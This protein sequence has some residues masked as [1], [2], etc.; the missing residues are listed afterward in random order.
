MIAERLN[1]WNSV[2]KVGYLLDQVRHAWYLQHY[3]AYPN[4][5]CWWLKL[6]FRMLFIKLY[7][8]HMQ[9]LCIILVMTLVSLAA[10]NL[11]RV[12]LLLGP[13]IREDR[14]DLCGQRSG[15]LAC[16][17]DDYLEFV[18]WYLESRVFPLVNPV[19]PLVDENFSDQWHKNFSD[20][21]GR[22]EVGRKVLG[23][24]ISCFVF[25]SVDF[26]FLI[27]FFSNGWDLIGSK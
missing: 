19:V 21:W 25:Y 15:M 26:S 18:Y 6:Y 3:F 10:G 4:S 20:H 2:W 9:P 14:R 1:H 22:W 27:L 7:E 24:S 17:D 5:I 13:R 11:T 8:Q 23:K 16:R 12:M